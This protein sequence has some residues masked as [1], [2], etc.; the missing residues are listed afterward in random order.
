MPIAPSILFPYAP[1]LGR[2]ATLTG[3]VVLAALRDGGQRTA[4][5]NAWVG[6]S[7]N[8]VVGRARREADLALALS[9]ARARA[10]TATPAAAGRRGTTG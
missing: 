3:S 2:A 7:S 10:G 6:M 1:L 4:R 8:A 5:R 9:E